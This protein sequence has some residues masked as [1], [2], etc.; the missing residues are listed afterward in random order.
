M[1]P[2]EWGA[3]MGVS[4]GFWRSTWEQVESLV[5]QVQ[6]SGCKKWD[7]EL[8]GACAKLAEGPAEGLILEDELGVPGWPLLTLG[9]YQGALR[10]IVLAAKH[11]RV[12]DLTPFL[13]QAGHTLGKALSKEPGLRTARGIW[14][15]PAPSSRAR[16]KAKAEIV[17][18]VAR[19]VAEQMEADLGIQVQVVPAVELMVARALLS[20]SQAGLSS[21]ARGRSRTGSMRRVLTSKAPVPMVVVDD[22]VA[23]GATVREMLRLLDPAV[24]AVAALAVSMR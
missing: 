17:P 14:V 6:C 9:D 19:A 3:M 21:R 18:L 1:G 11:D 2:G 7:T 23:S 4:Q 12:R 15:V 8:C 22:V 13:E 5:W 10:G 16:V 20:G 24:I